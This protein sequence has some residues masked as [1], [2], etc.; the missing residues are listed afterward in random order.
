MVP[1]GLVLCSLLLIVSPSTART[2]PSRTTTSSVLDDYHDGK[3]PLSSGPSAIP[4][5]SEGGGPPSGILWSADVAT[6]LMNGT[7]GPGVVADIDD[8]AAIVAALNSGLDVDL[9]VPVTGNAHVSAELSVT[10]F[11]QQQ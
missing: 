5:I 3:R 1:M 8:G 7:S 4:V 2:I 6:G 9:V 10:R 11:A